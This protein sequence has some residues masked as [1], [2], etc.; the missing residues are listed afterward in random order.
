MLL[1]RIP[2]TRANMADMIRGE[3]GATAAEYALLVAGVVLV[4]VFGVDALKLA[5]NLFYGGL[6]DSIDAWP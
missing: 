2:A 4:L 1:L 5:L 6:Q 3:R